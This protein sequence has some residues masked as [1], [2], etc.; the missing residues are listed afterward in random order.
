MSIE[1]NDN[2]IQRRGSCTP[3]D[4]TTVCVTAV[5]IFDYWI[6]RKWNLSIT[7]MLRTDTAPVSQ[8]SDDFGGRWCGTRRSDTAPSSRYLHDPFRG[9]AREGRV[10]QRALIEDVAAAGQPTKCRDALPGNIGRVLDRAHA[11]NLRELSLVLREEH[12]RA[13]PGTRPLYVHDVGDPGHQPDDAY[14]PLGLDVA[15]VE[16]DVDRHGNY[17]DKGK[18]SESRDEQAGHRPNAIGRGED[19]RVPDH[20]EHHAYLAYRRGRY[21][22]HLQGPRRHRAQGSYE[23]QGHHDDVP[24]QLHP[25]LR[26]AESIH[27]DPEERTQD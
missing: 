5:A 15:A 7:F 13:G 16:G 19:D 10:Q 25:V 26:P 24:H 27:D 23:R 17:W 20:E 12:W 4:G 18:G 2:A 14:P 22:H 6:L 9:A 8:S 3:P 21:S 1:G 11:V